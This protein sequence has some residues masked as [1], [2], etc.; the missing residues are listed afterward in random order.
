MSVVGSITMLLFIRIV[1]AIMVGI[2]TVT[3]DAIVSNERNIRDTARVLS[4]ITV[5]SIS[6]R[7][8]APILGGYTVSVYN[9]EVLTFVISG[10]AI[11]CLVYML[12]VFEESHP[13]EKQ[14]NFSLNIY[15]Q[16][17]RSLFEN[18]RVRTF[19]GME[20]L[21]SIGL[22]TYVSGSAYIFMEVHGFSSSGF[23]YI[24]ASISFV[25]LVAAYSNNLLV[26]RIG[27]EQ[28]IAFTIPGMFLFSMLVLL[29]DFTSP[30]SIWMFYIFLCLYLVS[31]MMTRIN[32]LAGAL[33]SVPTMAGSI[34]SVI[35]T[36]GFLAG[37]LT[38]ISLTYFFQF[39]HM[40][41]TAILF[42][43]ASLSLWLYLLNIKK[44]VIT[45]PY[46]AKP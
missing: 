1:Q 33:N 20:V 23:G 5:V 28:L 46:R 11:L 7:I 35:N 38:G 8:I 21:A 17:F 43:V 22:F 39:T 41:L 18:N 4:L 24:L 15:F 19:I 13:F 37:G 29:I 30:T 42:I 25:F 3:V 32:A 16:L 14:G 2:L 9:W 6:M 40:A 27:V 44:D 26:R 10:I 36:L 31:M 34:S 45:S 12:W